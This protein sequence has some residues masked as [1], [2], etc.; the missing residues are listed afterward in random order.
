MVVEQRLSNPV[1]AQVRTCMQ[2]NFLLVEQGPGLEIRVNK[3]DVWIDADGVEDSPGDR[4]E[5]GL[6]KLKIGA[7][8]DEMGVFTFHL[9]P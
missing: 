3:L 4:V 7:R 1:T 6:S 9:G 2:I 8:G 5:E